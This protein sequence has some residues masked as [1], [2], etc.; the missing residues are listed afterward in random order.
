MKTQKI[1]RATAISLLS[2]SFLLSSLHPVLAADCQ[3]MIQKHLDK[4]DKTGAG[5]IRA[6]VSMIRFSAGSGDEDVAGR[7]EYANG[8][9]SKK[10]NLLT[11]EIPGRWNTATWRPTPPN[12]V[13]TSFYC[14]PPNYLELHDLQPFAPNRYLTYGLKITNKGLVSISTLL[15]GKNFLGR[16]PVVFQGTCSGTSESDVITGVVGQK[17]YAIVLKSVSTP[18]IH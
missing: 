7:L 12:Y 4:L 3:A 9:I 16:A 8:G 10:Q 15:N 1:M 2:S 11:G 17:S 6:T 18:N 13:C 5:Y 14:P